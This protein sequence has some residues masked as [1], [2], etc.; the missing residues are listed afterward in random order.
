MAATHIIAPFLHAD[1]ADWQAI[2]LYLHLQESAEAVHLWA[3]QPPH[4]ALHRYPIQ[5]I[6]PYQQQAPLDGTLYIV[7]ATT[8]IGH[9]YAKG[10]FD[11]VVLMHN[12]FDQEAFYYC[13]HHL[14]AMQPQ[15]IEICYASRL[16]KDSIGFP[17][18]IRHPQP[19]AGRFCVLPVSPAQ[20]HRPFTVGRI[21]RDVKPTH[22]P[23]DIA[24]YRELAD[25]GIH[26]RIVG[27][28]CLAPWLSN[29]PNIELLPEIAPHEVPAMLASFDCFYYRV[30]LQTREAFG[31]VVAEATLSGLPVVAYD[32]GDYTDWLR[33]KPNGFLFRTNAEAVDRILDIR[34]NFLD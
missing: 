11:R 26:I 7:D 33:D 17:G 31:M 8:P 16:A 4:P 1:G 12:R 19:H 30:S 27:G 2:D 22:H 23:R 34:I 3:A 24:L 25:R 9:W 10:K 5:E 21:S 20:R 18:E 14:H 6:R 28:T 29:T 13:M 15:Q 32:G